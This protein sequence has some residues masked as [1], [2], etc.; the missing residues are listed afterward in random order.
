M[1]IEC[2]AHPDWPT[3]A[4]MVEDCQRLSWACTIASAHFSTSTP[5]AAT[6]PATEDDP[7]LA[8]YF[9]ALRCAFEALTLYGA[10]E[11]RRSA[12]DLAAVRT[13]PLAE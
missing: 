12:T 4:L 11:G 9:D 2:L 7:A 8:L 6:I 3:L 5:T 1:K 13:A 10:A